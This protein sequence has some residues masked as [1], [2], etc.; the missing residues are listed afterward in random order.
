VSES[1]ESDK[2]VWV[3]GLARNRRSPKCP[4]EPRLRGVHPEAG[5]V[6]KDGAAFR[7]RLSVG[8]GAVRVNG[9]CQ[10]SRSST[11]AAHAGIRDVVRLA[12]S[13]ATVSRSRR[14]NWYGMSHPLRPMSQS[15]GIM[16]ASTASQPLR[17]FTNT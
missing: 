7:L 12:F 16:R 8:W 3:Y 1:A 15:F 9:R 10:I 13:T 4:S 17:A 6:G 14:R 11:Q 5:V 2:P